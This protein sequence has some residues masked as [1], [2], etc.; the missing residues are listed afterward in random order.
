MAVFL[1]DQQFTVTMDGV[2]SAQHQQISGV[3]QGS[4][5]SVMLFAVNI[6]SLA[7]VIYEDIHSSLFVDDLQIFYRGM[8]IH[9]IEEKLQSNINRITDWAD[10]NGFRFSSSKTCCMGFDASRPH[11]LQPQLQMKGQQIPAVRTVK[12]L[13]LHW[14]Q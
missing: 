3:P 4:V 9:E 8:H 5:L 1:K 13:G 6:N 7:K 10:R 11:V 12:F 14:D 2:H